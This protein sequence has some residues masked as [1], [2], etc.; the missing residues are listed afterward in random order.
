LVKLPSGENFDF[1]AIGSPSWQPTYL[2]PKYLL[3]VGQWFDRIVPI[4]KRHIDTGCVVGVQID[5]E[6]N[7][8]WSD[9]FGTVDYSREAVD[10]Y[11]RFL[12]SRYATIAA[13]NAAYRAH[14]SSFEDVLPPT[15]LPR[16]PAENVAA[17]DWHDAGQA[18][19]AEYLSVARG[20]LEAR[21]VHEPDVLFLTN[22]SPFTIVG[23]VANPE[24]NI[25]VHDGTMK[26]RFGLAGLDAYPKQIPDLPGTDGPLTN[27]PFQADY[28]AKLYGFFGANYTRDPAHGFVFGAELQGGFY[29]LPGGIYPVVS[30]EATDRSNQTV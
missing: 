11:R 20:M 7:L 10:S 18:Y 6:T 26:N 9:R 28:F 24:R 14:Y 22:D 15:H 4:I 12:A 16:A 30:A 23:T 29:S 1:A 5:H 13:L 21:G 19:I 3:A 8:Y 17:R 25:L 2:H 27:F